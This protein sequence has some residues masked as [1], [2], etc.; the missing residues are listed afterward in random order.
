MQGTQVWSL[1][2]GLTSH[3]PHST[4]KIKRKMDINELLLSTSG[5]GFLSSPLDSRLTLG[6]PDQQNGLQVMLNQFWVSPLWG[7]LPLLASLGFLSDSVGKESAC[8]AGDLGSVPGL[9]GSPGEGYGYPHQYSGLSAPSYPQR[10]QAQTENPC[11]SQSR[12][13]AQLP[14]DT[15]MC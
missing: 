3:M 2:M 13:P 11:K 14:G 10:S 15:H 9:G 4:A 12:A 6:L 1:V 7:Q 8:N 5:G